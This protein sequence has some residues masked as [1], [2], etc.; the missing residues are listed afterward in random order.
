MPLAF[1]LNN[2]HFALEFFGAIILFV[3]AWLTADAF[4]LRRE[5]KVLLRVLGFGLFAFWLV[6]HAL[7]VTHDGILFLA[8][9]AY[10]AGLFFILLNLYL[11]KPPKRP[12][13]KLVLLLPPYFL[14]S[15]PS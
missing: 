3:L 12:T 1:L 11:E 7:N 14:A 4:L 6:I 15:S 8:A 10:I 13:F 9:A 5:L 2:I